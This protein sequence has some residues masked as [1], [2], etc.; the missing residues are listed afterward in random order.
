IIPTAI[1]Y[2]NVIINNIKGMND[3]MGKDAKTLASTQYE[4][5]KKTA[6]H[7]NK[8]QGACDKMLNERKI[9]NKIENSEGKALAYC[10]N[11]KPYFTEIKYHADKLELLIDDELWPLPKLRE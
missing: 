3:I 7:I 2:Q 5:L 6:E 11:V 9:S 8:L 1:K 10:D 4:I